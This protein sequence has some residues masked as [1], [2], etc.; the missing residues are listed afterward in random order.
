MRWFVCAA[1]CL[2]SLSHAL[3]LSETEKALLEES[4][5]WQIVSENSMG[6]TSYFEE[7]RQRL[8]SERSALESERQSLTT[9]SER[10]QQEKSAIERLRTQLDSDRKQIAEDLKSIAEREKRAAR[11][12]KLVK[13]APYVAVLVFVAGAVAGMAVK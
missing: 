11:V 7:E 9:E 2:A 10:L 8:S 5:L 1:L 12:E 6:L 13:A 3:E 4:R